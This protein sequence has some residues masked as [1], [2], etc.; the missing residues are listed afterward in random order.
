VVK[1]L[2][3]SL[4][5]GFLLLF[6]NVAFVDNPDWSDCYCSAYENLFRS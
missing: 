5:D 3:P 1:E 2:A 4:R 6:E